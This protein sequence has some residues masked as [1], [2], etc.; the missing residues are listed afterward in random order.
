MAADGSYSCGPADISP[1]DVFKAAYEQCL[2]LQPRQ[3]RLRVV[4]NLQRPGADKPWRLAEVD[5]HNER[6]VH[7]MRGR[8]RVLA[9]PPAV[10]GCWH[11]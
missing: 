3:R 11:L 4:H 10:P 6:W 7:G 9:L 1:A 5:L 8:G 2:V